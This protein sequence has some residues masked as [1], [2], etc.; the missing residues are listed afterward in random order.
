M[1]T[2]RQGDVNARILVRDADHGDDRTVR[3]F[4]AVLLY[5]RVKENA[6]RFAFGIENAA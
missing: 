3:A 5:K 6:E 2:I 1:D 4:G